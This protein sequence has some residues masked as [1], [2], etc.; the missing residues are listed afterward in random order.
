MN[1]ENINQEAVT[2]AVELEKIEKKHIWKF[3]IASLVGAFLFLVPIP[4]GTTFTIP[5]GIVIDWVSAL[6]GDLASLLVLVFITVS[7]ILTIINMIAYIVLTL[8]KRMCVKIY[9]FKAHIIP[10]F[11]NQLNYPKLQS[12]RQHI[13]HK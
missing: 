1:N 5:L 7:C 3:V 6:L 10:S 8:N 12:F 4:N 2:T 13:K 9:Y 11:Q